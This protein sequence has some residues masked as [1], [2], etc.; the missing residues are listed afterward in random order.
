LVAA[1][2]FLAFER[3]YTRWLVADPR[4]AAFESRRT[5]P[6]TTPAP[7]LCALVISLGVLLPLLLS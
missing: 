1:N 2:L 3:R 5:R 4:F 7:A 6:V